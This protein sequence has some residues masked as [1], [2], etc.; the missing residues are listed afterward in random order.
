MLS[1]F[2]WLHIHTQQY[3]RKEKV[4]SKR[5]F[6]QLGGSCSKYSLLCQRNL[7]TLNNRPDVLSCSFVYI[8]CFLAASLSWSISQMVVLTPSLLLGK[9]LCHP[10]PREK[11]GH[12]PHV[13]IV[14]ANSLWRS[15]AVSSRAQNHRIPHKFDKP[16]DVYPLPSSRLGSERWYSSDIIYQGRITVRPRWVDQWKNTNNLIGHLTCIRHKICF[17]PLQVS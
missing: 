1:L 3:Y 12:L 14:S 17:N 7:V 8:T 2:I 5:S 15:T 10:S 16:H 13:A 6:L 11:V 4:V 9:G